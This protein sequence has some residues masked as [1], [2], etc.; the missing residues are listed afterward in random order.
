M[1]FDD[2]VKEY[3]MRVLS[4]DKIKEAGITPLQCYTWVSGSIM[5][6]TDAILPAKISLK[7]CIPGVFYNTM[8]CII[9]GASFFGG[10]CCPLS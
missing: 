1:Q 3:I 8:P 10:A 4:F 2:Q 9:P 5:H 7:P 6:K